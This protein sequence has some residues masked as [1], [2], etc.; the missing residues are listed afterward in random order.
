MPKSRRVQ[1]LGMSYSNPCGRDGVSTK[2]CLTVY[3]LTYMEI[4]GTQVHMISTSDMSMPHNFLPCVSGS[5][6]RCLAGFVV[7]HAAGIPG[8]SFAECIGKFVRENHI[9]TDESW[10]RTWKKAC[11][12]EEMPHQVKAVPCRGTSS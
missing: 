3:E 11:L 6:N 12:G 10:K 9:Q 7:R 8:G 1:P 4:D 2:S 5:D